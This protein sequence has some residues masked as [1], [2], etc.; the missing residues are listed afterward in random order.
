M[1]SKLT[2]P[3]EIKSLSEGEFEGHGSVF[4]NEDLGGDVV[5][6]GAF[7][8][9]LAEHKAAGELPQ[10]FWMHDP[11][12]VP[13]K[14]LSM[15]EDAH[16]LRVKG[17]L[18]DTPLGNEIRTLLKMDAVK[19]LSIGYQTRDQDF[20]DD[21]TRLI[22]EVDLWEVSV[23]SLP[24]NPLAQVAHAKSRLSEFG[25]YVPTL[26]EFERILREAGCSRSTAKKLVH[27]MMTEKTHNMTT[28]KTTPCEAE[29]EEVVVEVEDRVEAVSEPTDDDIARAV[30]EVAESMF[31]A[32]IRKPR[33]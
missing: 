21:G 22:K 30:N 13:G 25:E 29:P 7:K 24:M 16:G 12:K 28:E 9:S 17:V 2:I 31:A 15:E 10:M 11:S 8:R 27:N 26:K 23:V 4:G 3:L 5:V 19:G 18:A 14:W 33:I 1:K 6:K 20:D 32:T